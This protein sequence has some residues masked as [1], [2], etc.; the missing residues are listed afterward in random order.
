MWPVRREPSELAEMTTEV[1]FGEGVECLETQGRWTRI[2]TV[3]EGYEGWVDFKLPREFGEREVERW[4]GLPLEVVT[5]PGCRVWRSGMPTPLLLPAGAE[6][7]VEHEAE[8]FTLGGVSY[9]FDRSELEANRRGSLHETA[10]Q[11]LGAPYLWGGRTLMG[12]DCSGFVQLVYKLLGYY[13]P[14]D[15]SQ[16]IAFGREIDWR[17][18]PLFEGDLLFFRNADGNVCHVALSL[19]GARLIHASGSVRYDT[20]ANGEIF[21]ADLRR[22]THSNLTVKRL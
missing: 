14:R 9:L 18:Q 5:A 10:E 22:V 16:M 6:L 1:L 4:R 15:A 7:R 12:I 3:N 11:L 20:L 8:T 13:L 2:R 19:G 17:Q 21:N